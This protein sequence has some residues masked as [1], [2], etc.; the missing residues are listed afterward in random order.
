MKLLMLVISQRSNKN[1]FLFFVFEF[2]ECCAM[3]MNDLSIMERLL[4]PGWLS[5]EESACCAGTQ[6]GSL[7]Q[8]YPPE[9]EMAT[10]SS[11]PA[12]EIPWTEEPG[13]LQ[14]MGSQRVRH[15]WVTEHTHTLFKSRIHNCI[16]RQL[17]LCKIDGNRKIL[18]G[19]LWVIFFMSLGFSK[20]SARTAV[21]C[22]RL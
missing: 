16:G 20:C 1:S 19:E 17:Q 12:W 21:S 2:S 4:L 14:S 22:L 7:D 5:G 8:E 3:N 13:G 9:K 10:H 15:D 11:V 18:M 6:V